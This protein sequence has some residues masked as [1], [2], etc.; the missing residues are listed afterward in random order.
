VLV[1]D[2]TQDGNGPVLRLA[3]TDWQ[4]FTARLGPLAYN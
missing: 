1:R 3:P 2:T 4:R